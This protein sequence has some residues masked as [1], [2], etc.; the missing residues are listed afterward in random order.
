[1]T[2][3]PTYGRFFWNKR[4]ADDLKQ[5]SFTSMKRSQKIEVRPPY[6]G[7]ADAYSLLAD[8][9]GAPGRSHIKAHRTRPEALALADSWPRHT[10][11]LLCED[12]LLLGLERS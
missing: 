8:Y 11:S 3:K 7:L 2:I 9:R 12:V 10:T 4:T 6:A 1:M 5:A